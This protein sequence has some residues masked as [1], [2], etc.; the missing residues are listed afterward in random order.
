MAVTVNV[1]GSAVQPLVASDMPHVDGRRA[2]AIIRGRHQRHDT[3]VRGRIRGIA[4]QIRAGRD[5]DVGGV[6]SAVQ[7]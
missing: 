3:G 4:A 2:A 7:V 1:R 5:R 6:V